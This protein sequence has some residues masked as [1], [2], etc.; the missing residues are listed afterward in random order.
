MQEVPETRPRLFETVSPEV[1]TRLLEVSTRLSS[2]LHLDELLDLV[3][4]AATDL[5]NTQVGSILLVDE[6]T[7][8][9]H[10]AA[11]TR[12]AVPEDIIVPLDNSIAGWVVRNGRS[13]ILDDVQSDKRFYATVDKDLQFVTQSMLAVPLITNN[14]TIGALEVI[15]KIDHS[16]YTPQDVALME[17][18]ASQ[19]AVAIM[20]A[21]LFSQSDL[22]AEIMHELKTPLMAIRSASELMSRPNFPQ[23]KHVELV[24]MIRREAIRLS[25]MTK[26]FLDF[27]RLES[28]R[29]RLK[30]EVVDLMILIL[31][32]VRI[33]ESQAAARHITITTQLPDDLP[34]ADRQP[35]LQ[36]D[37]DR[38]KQVLLNF[39]SNAIKYNVENGRITI[40]AQCSDNEIRI[41]IADTGHGIAA[42]DMVHLF[43]RFYRVP[44]SENAAEGSGMGLA[45]AKKIVEQH[46]GR[47]EV[48]ST[49]GEGTIFTIVLPLQSGDAS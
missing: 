23:E 33:A 37:G 7:G 13:L 34:R 24:N 46:G 28:G 20:N 11:S 22:L 21:R 32:V 31:D 25:N 3:M 4:V 1:L 30:N 39:V 2:T 36:G 18:I 47:I 43:E 14:K 12:G 5:T 15:N 10:F 26:D 8:Q 35:F 6:V 48:A 41:G 17:A 29:V 38:L 42:E 19:S 16:G 45:I 27:A 49:V 44:Q 40:T 9:L